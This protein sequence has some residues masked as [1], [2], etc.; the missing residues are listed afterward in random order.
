MLKEFEASY[1]YIVRLFVSENQPTNQQNPPTKP[2]QNPN[3]I[4]KPD[5]LELKFLN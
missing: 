1:S 5:K 2:N 3:L 4:P